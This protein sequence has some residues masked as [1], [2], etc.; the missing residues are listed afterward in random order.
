MGGDLSFARTT[1]EQYDRMIAMGLGELDKSGIASS[2]SKTATNVLAIACDA[3]I[4]AFS[5]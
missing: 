3:A 5:G 2:H 4:Q 1:K